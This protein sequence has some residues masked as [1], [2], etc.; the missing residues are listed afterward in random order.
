MY[1]FKNSNYKNAMHV[2]LLKKK[3]NKN[4]SY[5]INFIKI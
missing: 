4:G 5:I 3:Q 2:I 1:I